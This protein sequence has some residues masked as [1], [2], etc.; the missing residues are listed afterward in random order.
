MLNFYKNISLQKKNFYYYK[1]LLQILYNNYINFFQ[2]P[3]FKKVQFNDF[4]YKKELN[5]TE[6][7]LC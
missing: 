4:I 3:F 7:F 6:E 1:F 5:I 2:K